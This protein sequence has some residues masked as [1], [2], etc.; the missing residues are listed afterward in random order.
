[1]QA[2]ADA[3]LHRATIAKLA[4]QLLPLAAFAIALPIAGLFAFRWVE[5]TV[6][7][8]GELDLY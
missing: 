4:P 5:R 8:R 2:L 3:A 6:R 1:M 7:E